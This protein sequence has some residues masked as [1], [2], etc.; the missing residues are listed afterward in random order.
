[1]ETTKIIYSDAQSIGDVRFAPKADNQADISLCPLCAIT[2]REQ[3]QQSGLLF[4]DLVGACDERRR[5]L[6][7]EHLGCP[8]VDDQLEFARLQHR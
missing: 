6:K 5:Y 1:M 8:G 2:G 3:S 4:D 7:A